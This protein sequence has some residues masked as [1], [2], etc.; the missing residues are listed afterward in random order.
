MIYIQCLGVYLKLCAMQSCM[1]VYDLILWWMI[2]V[3]SNGQT[4][5]L[6]WVG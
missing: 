2:R 3:K 4:D 1:H 6:W 5:L